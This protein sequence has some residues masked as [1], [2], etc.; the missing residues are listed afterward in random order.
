MESQILGADDEHD[1]MHE[2][3]EKAQPQRSIRTPSTP[4]AEE[5]AEH[6]DDGHLPYR[7]WWSD[8]VEAFGRE[9]LLKAAGSL[10]QRRISLLPSDYLLETQ[11]GVVSRNE[12][13]EEEREAS[14]TVLVIYCSAIRSAFAHAMPKK[15]LDPDGYIVEQIRD[16]VL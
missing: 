14:L 6:C 10:H 16:D 3:E 9:C 8:C 4:S 11:K 15:G 1:E 2:P 5:M 12:L 13:S 7:S